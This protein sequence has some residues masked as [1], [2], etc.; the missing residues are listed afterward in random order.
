MP[1]EHF[2]FRKKNQLNKLDKSIKQGWDVRIK[3]LCDKIN[4]ADNY[5]TT[6]SC[7]GRIMLI[8]DC[9]EKRDDLFIAVWHENIPFEKIRTELDKLIVLKPKK[10]IYFKQEPCILHVACKTLEDAQKIHDL[11][12]F[13]G[14]K[15]CGIISSKKRFVV[16]LNATQRIEFPIFYSGKTLASE[17][18]LKFALD[19]A[20]KKLSMSWQCIDEFEKRFNL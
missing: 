7:S 17:E 6:S 14:W 15:R 12:K 2:L 5:Y 3:K 4:L 9:K 8:T 16:E 1:K 19:E 10:L 13:S 11:A 18:F 20:N